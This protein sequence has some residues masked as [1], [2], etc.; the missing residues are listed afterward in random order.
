M[1]NPKSNSAPTNTRRRQYR[2]GQ[3]SIS[4]INRVLQD[5]GLRLDQVDAIGQD[6]D[7]KG[8]ILR[9][10][11]PES[12]AKHAAVHQDGGVDEISINGL[13]GEAADE[14]KSTWAKVSG[15]PAT[16][17]PSAHAA[18]HQAAGADEISIAALSGEAADEQKSAWAKVSGKPSTFD[19]IAH[20]ARHTD[21][22]DDIQNA[23]AAQKG[24]A[25]AAQIT[26][27]DAI[28]AAADVTDATNV[29]AAGA[30]MNADT[31]VKANSWVIDEDNMASNLDTK[32]PTQQSVKKYVDDNAG[33]GDVS[34]ASNLTDNCVVRGNGGVKGV[35][36][37]TVVIDDSGRMTKPGQ[38]AF[39]ARPTSIQTNMPIGL[40]RTIVFGTEIFDQGNN[41]ATPYFTAPVTGR[42]QFNFGLSTINI[43]QACSRVTVQLVTSNRTYVKEFTSTYDGYWQ[44]GLSVLADMDANDIAY[45]QW[46]QIG[47]SA[48]TDI[49]I[50]SFF[51]GVLIC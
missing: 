39:L 11:S 50:G 32:V 51:S 13:S 40:P 29:D 31:N 18:D 7:V 33:G 36:T 25:T 28:E 46:F 27:L 24:L 14:Q 35:Q 9:N 8:R 5:I 37:S 20:A 22:N 43:Q 45:V 48:I 6:P 12:L 34:A 38:P 1:S 44:G 21:G 30:T 49:E 19:P 2:I 10:I 15:K 42:Y 41:F 26:K 16:F 23:T 17:T 3:V 47:G 4:E